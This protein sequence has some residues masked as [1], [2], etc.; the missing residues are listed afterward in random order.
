MCHVVNVVCQVLYALSVVSCVVPV[1]CDMCCVMCCM[2]SVSVV[3]C[4]C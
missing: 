4:T 2:L 1:E 3:C